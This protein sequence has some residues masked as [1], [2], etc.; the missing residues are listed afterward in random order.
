MAKEQEKKETF[1]LSKTTS[2]RGN[3]R[4]VREKI[5]Q[6]LVAHYI[7]KTNIEI[8]F[9]HIFARD[10]LFDK[11]EDKKI[12]ENSPEKLLTRAEL[13]ELFADKT[14][15]WRE[16]DLEFGKNLLDCCIKNQDLI[17]STL[18]IISENWDFERVAIIDRAIIVI[19]A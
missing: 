6:I 9:E 5:L 16:Q 10:F 14:I 15:D 18:K 3:R 13:D 4:V 19:G 1:P 2:V 8:L 17:D 12:K 7:S 11:D